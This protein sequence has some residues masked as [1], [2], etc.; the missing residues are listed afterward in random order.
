MCTRI[1]TEWSY[2][3]DDGSLSAMCLNMVLRHLMAFVCNNNDKK[4]N[5]GIRW[6]CFLYIKIMFAFHGIRINTYI[7]IDSMELSRILSKKPK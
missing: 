3:D 4:V 6:S 1:K 5:D 7:V 2:D